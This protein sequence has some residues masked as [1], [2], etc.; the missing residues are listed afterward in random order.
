MNE[1][2]RSYQ[3]S[4]KYNLKKTLISLVLLGLPFSF[5][6]GAIYSLLITI[7]PVSFINFILLLIL[8]TFLFGI[9]SLIQNLGQSRSIAANFIIGIICCLSAYYGNWWQVVH[10]ENTMFLSLFNLKAT[11]NAILNYLSMH[12][13][14]LFHIELSP[15]A[16]KLLDF[17]EMIAFFSVA[18]FT[19]TTEIYCEPCQR[20]NV[21]YRLYALETKKILTDVEKSTPGH[22]V[23][24]KNKTYLKNKLAFFNQLKAKKEK[25]FIAS[26]YLYS[27]CTKCRNNGFLSLN[28]LTL[29]HDKKQNKI[30]QTVLANKINHVRID[31][32][33]TSIF[34]N[35]VQETQ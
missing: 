8:M 1:I 3:P 11:F 31:E 6:L 24:A 18:F 17:V 2:G 34:E 7:N 30:K 25:Q 32:I 27:Q 21:I 16:S 19:K 26:E 35:E 28:V 4:G 10:A 22:Y 33:T 23:F 20:F 5:L 14:T 15:F 13:I 29:E 9:I 12:Q